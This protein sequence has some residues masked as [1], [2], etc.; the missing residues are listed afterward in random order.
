MALNRAL[1]LLAAVLSMSCSKK[2]DPPR[3]TEPWPAQSSAAPQ[4]SSGK[5]LSY[6]FAPD[7]RVSFHVPGRRA[8]LRGTVPLAGGSL[9]LDFSDLSRSKATLHA[10]LMA[11]E[12]DE[13]TLPPDAGIESA[14]AS[15]SASARQWLELGA[16][17]PEEQRQFFGRATFE[18][19]SAEPVGA[20]TSARA[21]GT[22]KYAAD[23]VGTLL[24]HGFR[25]PV[26]ARVELET[27]P[28]ATE[29]APTVTIR[30]R[31]PLVVS[32]PAHDV[33]ARDAA[34]VPLPL[35]AARLS[36][37]MGREARIEA[38]LTALPG[39]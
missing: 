39:N 31:S 33:T 3:R 24:V 10:D 32:L 23:V 6:R 13:A 38:E 30:T 15:A 36:A 8:T 18:L 4:A 5:R 12:L 25:A 28:G 14:S 35:E 11:L 16:Q 34:G 17:V 19:V 37:G 9:S 21:D 29:G 27:R 7:S 22:S 1:A 20:G 26:R 2:S